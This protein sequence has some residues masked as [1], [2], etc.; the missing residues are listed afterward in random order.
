[1]ASVPQG[2]LAGH[3]P[4]RLGELMRLVPELAHRLPQFPVPTRTDPQAER[5]L[6]FSAVAGLLSE[7]ASEMPVI[8]A[9]DDLH[10]ADRPTLLL[11]RHLAG[12]SLRRVLILCTYR[13]VA[14]VPG[15]SLA[16]ALAALCREPTVDRIPLHGLDESAVAAV[17][18]AMGAARLMPRAGGWPDPTGRLTATHSWSSSMFATCGGPVC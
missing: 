15:Q 3:D 6:L 9:L 18:A 4:Q 13:D 12:A 5:Y 14:P 8:L 11:L 1:M 2:R 17:M 7:I 10:W 16:E